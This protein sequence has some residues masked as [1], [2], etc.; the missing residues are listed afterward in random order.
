MASML[1]PASLLRCL[2]AVGGWWSSLPSDP[3]LIGP[4]FAVLLPDFSAKE[5]DVLL[6]DTSGRVVK[7]AMTCAG[8]SFPRISPSQ[9]RAHQGLVCFIGTDERLRVLD[10]ATGAVTVLPDLCKTFCKFVLGRAASKSK[11]EGGGGEYKVLSITVNGQ[12]QDCKVLTLA[13]GG[14]GDGGGCAWRDAPAPPPDAIDP[15]ISPWTVA[16]AE[17]VV[18][19][20]TYH[21]PRH[22]GCILLFDLETEQWRPDLLQG[23]PTGINTVNSLA[24]VDGRLVAVSYSAST[25]DPWLLMGSGDG[26]PALWR[27]LCKIPVS[28]IQQNDHECVHEP[29]WV[30]EGGRV[31]FWVWSPDVGCSD[32][33]RSRRNVL[34]VYDPRTDTC[35]DVA[36]IPN[37]MEFGVGLYT[38]NR[39]HVRSGS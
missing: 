14:G 9:L 20:L 34:R 13:H 25:I 15:A 12:Q 30:L 1:L 39:P 38:G 4:L 24:E 19:F 36:R 33:L 8:A 10:P 5:A 11:G 16:V 21:V 37:G 23:P 35:D 6:L 26:E 22:K 3:D 28:R 2:R 29:L 27:E 17:G 18:Y 7:R 31:A 32:E